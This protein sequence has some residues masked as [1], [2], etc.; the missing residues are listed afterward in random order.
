MDARDRLAGV[1]T[2]W[3][4]V[5]SLITLLLN[6]FWL[7]RAAPGIITGKLSDFAGI[8][9][10]T[11]LLLALTPR[12]SRTVYLAVASGF[13]YWKCGWS[14]PVIEALNAYL[15][16]AVGRTIDPGDLV[17]LLV[18]PACTRV[19]TRPAA[20][21]IPGATLRRLLVWP[22]ASATALALMATSAISY[23]HEIKVTQRDPAAELNH[24]VLAAAMAD[25]MAKQKMD[26]RD[27]ADTGTTASY[28]GKRA[29]LTYSFP[30]GRTLI[31]TIHGYPKG[32]IMPHG[33]RENAERVGI[34]VK[35][36][37]SKVYASLIFQERAPG[38]R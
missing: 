15:P 10:V 33:S 29:N 30:D 16:I 2:T 12:W 18:M 7:K 34:A 9:I 28:F 13:V 26:C 25:V 6:D 8:A 37:L 1:I 32:I 19:L 3:P 22:V 38:I 4:F 21:R 11:L 24:T 14:Q 23:P 36:R 31:V 20:F 35:T 17:A 27:C 5:L